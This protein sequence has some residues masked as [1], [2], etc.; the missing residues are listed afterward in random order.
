MN[1]NT[2][3]P[4]VVMLCVA[5]AVATLT[6]VS[7]FFFAWRKRP[8]TEE[9]LVPHCNLEERLSQIANTPMVEGSPDFARARPD[10]SPL[11]S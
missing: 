10:G 6:V 7:G 2:T 3:G 11:T 5:A 4:W 9:N 8:D 1:T